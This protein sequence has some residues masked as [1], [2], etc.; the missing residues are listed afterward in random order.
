[1]Q[2]FS[3]HDGQKMHKQPTTKHLNNHTSTTTQPPSHHTSI[4]NA[5]PLSAK[6]LSNVRSNV[7]PKLSLLD[8][9]R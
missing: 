1:M 2:C 9:N 8:T 3:A 4:K 6:Y 7:A 5:A